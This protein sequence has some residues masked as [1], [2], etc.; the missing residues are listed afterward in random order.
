LYRA[1]SRNTCHSVCY[2]TL[3]YGSAIPHTWCSSSPPFLHSTPR[4]ARTHAAT[5]PTP[6]STTRRAAGTRRNAIASGARTKQGTVHGAKRRSWVDSANLSLPSHC[7]LCGTAGCWLATPSPPPPANAR[8]PSAIGVSSPLSL[9]PFSPI[10][11]NERISV[12][13]RR[14]GAFLL[15]RFILIWYLV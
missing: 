11:W 5:Q 7:T 2:S 13:H 4:D 9:L 8:R 6:V 1:V 15:N 14:F 10:P 12:P 3:L